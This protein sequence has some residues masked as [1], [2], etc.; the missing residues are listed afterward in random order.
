[1]ILSGGTPR[2]RKKSS[3]HVPSFS[4]TNVNRWSS[5]S[6][7]NI[8][9][10]HYLIFSFRCLRS[11]HAST[12]AHACVCDMCVIPASARVFVRVCARACAC[13]CV[14][15]CVCVL[16]CVYVCVRAC[17][18]AWLRACVCVCIVFL[19]YACLSSV[20]VHPSGDPKN[21]DASIYY[22]AKL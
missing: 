3:Q 12:N 13:V 7:T 4:A 8:T 6:S 19:L 10:H 22:L 16:A 18:R 1:M 17:V 5:G 21:S 9:N 20:I 2:L 14:R 11:A 15:T